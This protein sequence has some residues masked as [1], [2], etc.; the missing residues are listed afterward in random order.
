[1]A[2]KI[3]GE[4]YDFF[5]PKIVKPLSNF[6]FEKIDEIVN[7]DKNINSLKN[8]IILNKI[9]YSNNAREIKK[10]QLGIDKFNGVEESK[11]LPE[12][13][14]IYYVP[15]SFSL[16]KRDLTISESNKLIISINENKKIIDILTEEESKLE[17]NY[18]LELAQNKIDVEEYNN[19]IY[20]RNIALRS[21]FGVGIASGIG[22]PL[23][24]GSSLLINDS[25]KKQKK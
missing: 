21:I 16:N 19:K 8:E 4:V 11:Y 10:I 5:L 18:D 25:I 3:F 2:S 22:I 1:M 14:N 24:V 20:R 15:D 7:I 17:P 13:E 9:K 12:D 23:I 6:H